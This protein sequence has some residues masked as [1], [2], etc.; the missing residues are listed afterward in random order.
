MYPS[1]RSETLREGKYHWHGHLR[2]GVF[3]EC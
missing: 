1:Y 2:N 3:E